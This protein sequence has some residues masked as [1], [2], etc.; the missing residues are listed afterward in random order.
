M[1]LTMEMLVLLCWFGKVWSLK[2]EGVMYH[3]KYIY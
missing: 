3:E 1:A 2:G